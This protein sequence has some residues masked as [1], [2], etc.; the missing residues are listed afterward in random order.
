VA[1]RPTDPEAMQLFQIIGAPLLAVIQAE[2]QAAQVSAEFI[3]RIGFDSPPA[4]AGQAAGGAAGA[5]G[6]PTALQDGGALGGLRMA[7]FRIER[8]GADGSPQ[9]LVARV[10][11]LSLFPIPLLQVK[12]ADFE[13]DIR[14]LSRVPLAHEPEISPDA[15]QGAPAARDQPATGTAG[16]TERKDT[17]ARPSLSSDFLSKDRVEL[18]GFLA[19]S[20][21]AG[22][23]NSVDANIKVRVRMEQSDLPAGL[24]HLL[25]IMGDNVT[26]APLALLEQ[27]RKDAGAG[28]V[29]GNP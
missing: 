28:K 10:P 21:G 7:E 4:A 27:P 12:H 15:D 11:V 13:F 24:I 26:V 14:V 20:R 2:A 29:Q 17:Q 5:L 16:A 3:K 1:V 9:P 8:Y 23:T 25:K 6:E 19:P 22:D 18:K